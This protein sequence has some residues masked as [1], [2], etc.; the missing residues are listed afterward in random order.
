MG[1]E[2]AGIVEEVGAAATTVRP[3]QFVI[4]SFVASDNTC[5]ICRAGYHSVCIHRQGVSGAQ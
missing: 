3:G 4:G 5:E 2:Y 1:Q